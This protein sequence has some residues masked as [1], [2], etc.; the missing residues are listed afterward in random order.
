MTEI[1]CILIIE[2]EERKTKIKR[3]F[4]HPD[5]EGI[6]NV[7]WCFGTEI[8]QAIVAITCDLPN[9]ADLIKGLNAVYKEETPD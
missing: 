8:A 4:K 1:T 2:D 3:H 5:V 6:A 9:S 7:S